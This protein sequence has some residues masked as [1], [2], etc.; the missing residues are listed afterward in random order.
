MFQNL[1]IQLQRN[2]AIDIKATRVYNKDIFDESKMWIGIDYRPK[3][4]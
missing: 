2:N 3:Q 4:T 1:I